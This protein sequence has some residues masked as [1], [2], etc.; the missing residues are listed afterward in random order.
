MIMF[1]GTNLH[2]QTILYIAFYPANATKSLRYSIRK[3]RG[4]MGMLVKGKL[5]RTFGIHFSR[6]RTHDDSVLHPNVCCDWT[7]QLEN[8]MPSRLRRVGRGGKKEEER[9]NK[10]RS[11]PPSV[12]VKNWKEFLGW[13]TK[14]KSRQQVESIRSWEHVVSLSL[15][16]VQSFRIVV[17]DIG[18]FQSFGESSKNLDWLGLAELKRKLRFDRR[19]PFPVDTALKRD[20][21]VRDE[22]NTAV[23]K[24]ERRPLERPL[25]RH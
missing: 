13:A 3:R 24:G 17:I 16:S 7:C 12:R 15:D 19:V 22:L 10:K 21:C 18:I 5:T 25:E 4:Q 20:S 2:F 23:C 11:V 6:N 8:R 9:E 1:H 14:V